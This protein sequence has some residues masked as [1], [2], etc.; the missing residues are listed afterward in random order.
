MYSPEFSTYDYSQ[1]CNRNFRSATSAEQNI[2]VTDVDIPTEAYNKLESIQSSITPASLITP[3]LSDLSEIFTE[4]KQELDSLAQKHMTNPKRVSR[5]RN[6]FGN[7]SVRFSRRSLDSWTLD[8]K[9]IAG[10]RK[11]MIWSSFNSKDGRPRRSFD[12]VG[13]TQYPST[14]RADTSPAITTARGTLSTQKWRRISRSL[15]L[16]NGFGTNQRKLDV[17]QSSSPV[18]KRAAAVQFLAKSLSLRMK[19]L[20]SVD[21]ERPSILSF[22]LIENRENDPNPQELLASFMPHHT[23]TFTDDPLNP[24]LQR[25]SKSLTSSSYIESPNYH[26]TVPSVT[27]TQNMGRYSD[28]SG[29]LE[30][31]I[32]LLTRKK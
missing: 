8:D 1:L 17:D 4:F 13:E 14:S 22:P 29:L 21:E 15:D 10:E 2:F 27:M 19:K 11:S 7:N 9:L 5:H 26:A 12:S 31:A 25:E 32:L 23:S 20:D 24:T 28:G 3:S 16:E 6:S 18:E 30:A